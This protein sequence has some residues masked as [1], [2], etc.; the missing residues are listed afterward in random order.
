MNWTAYAACYDLM[1]ESNPAY[2]ELF[3]LIDRLISS[4]PLADGD[5]VLELGSGTGN[6]TCRIAAALPK[7]QITAIDFDPGMIGIAEAKC[8]REHLPNVTFRAG[9]HHDLVTEDRTYSLVV[10]VHTIYCSSTPHPLLS[11]IFSSLRPGGAALLIDLGRRMDVSDWRSYIF[12]DLVSREGLLKA[13]HTL[14]RGRM[15][16]SSNHA[17]REQQDAGRYWVHSSDEFVQA[18]QMAGFEV[19]EHGLCYRDYSDW[20]LAIRSTD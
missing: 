7:C 18:L 6:F 2:Q 1:A 10:A 12:R 15:V 17:I 11:K 5:S 3:P 19:R 14:W 13:V 9:D 16:A 4:L 20:A 8:R